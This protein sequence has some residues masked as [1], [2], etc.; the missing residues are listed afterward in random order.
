[1]YLPTKRSDR[2]LYGLACPFLVLFLGIS[3][4]TVHYLWLPLDIPTKIV[5][6]LVADALFLF[7][8]VFALG[9]IWC[10]FTP[11]W[12]ARLLRRRCVKVIFYSIVLVIGLVVVLVAT[13][14]ARC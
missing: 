14:I 10:I 2:I 7:A 4:L 8:T 3:C 12:V 6:Y 1:M 13:E 5:K 11:E 9:F